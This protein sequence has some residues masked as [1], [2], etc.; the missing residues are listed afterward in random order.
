MMKNFL[1]E[2]F[3]QLKLSFFTGYFTAEKPPTSQTAAILTL[4]HMLEAWQTKVSLGAHGCWSATHLE[5]AVSPSHKE[6]APSVFA[7]ISFHSFDEWLV[8]FS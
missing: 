8:V 5:M 2:D 1:P 4:G 3:N 7:T 6:T